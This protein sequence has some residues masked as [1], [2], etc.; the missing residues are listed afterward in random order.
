[1]TITYMYTLTLKLARHTVDVKIAIFL[2]VK[3]WSN[4]L[5]PDTDLDSDT[6]TDTGT[7]TGAD[8]DRHCR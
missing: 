3:M 5:S 8:T 6:G 4:L 2:E 7:A 1:M